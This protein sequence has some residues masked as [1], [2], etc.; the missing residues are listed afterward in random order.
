MRLRVVEFNLFLTNCTTRI[1]FRFGISTLT[2][3]PLCTAQVI[4]ETDGGARSEGYSADL[5]VPKWFEKDPRKPAEDDVRALLRSAQA[6]GAWLS[7]TDRHEATVFD[8]WWEL[9]QQRVESQPSGA[10]DLLVHGFGVALME[11]AMMD[12]ACR[13]AEQSFFA[14]LPCMVAPPIEP[15]R[16]GQA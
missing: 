10:P 1:P 5:L 4:I 13:A 11:R 9:Y 2:F 3:A 12:A 8:H 6:A 16:P 14:A 7:S 15:M